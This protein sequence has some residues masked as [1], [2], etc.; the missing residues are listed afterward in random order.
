MSD[1]TTTRCP[2]T[3]YLV[4]DG[5]KVRALR[6]QL[7]AGHEVDAP[8]CEECDDKGVVCSRG[9]GRP[10]T[11]HAVTFT[12]EDDAELAADWPEAYDPD[13]GFDVDVAPLP[14]AELERVDATLA[15]EAEA[16]E[17]QARADE[18]AA[19]EDALRDTVAE[20]AADELAALAAIVDAQVDARRE[21][22]AFGDD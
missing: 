9:G 4:V 17:R 8:R 18:R 22:R 11:P 2:V 16:I 19:L 14:D 12:W 21:A 10:G 15:A 1:T 6:C 7:D 5:V 3:G 13:E 20:L